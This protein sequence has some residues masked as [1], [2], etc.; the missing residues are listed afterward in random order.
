MLSK[1]CEALLHP[2]VSHIL[3]L[4]RLPVGYHNIDRHTDM[5]YV[6]KWTDF[7]AKIVD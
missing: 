7:A 6:S 3:R 5:S 2:A 1:A 4:V